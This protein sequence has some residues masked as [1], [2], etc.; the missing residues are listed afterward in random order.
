MVDPRKRPERATFPLDYLLLLGL[1]MLGGQCGSRRQLGRELTGSRLS[2]NVWKLAGKTCEAVCHTDTMNQV[3][4]GL[5][6]AGIERLIVLMAGRLRE[7]KMLRR[8]LLNG[9]LVVAMDGVQVMRV[10][11]PTGSGWLTQTNDGKTTY[12]HYVLAAKIITACGLV[13]PF[14]FEFIENPMELA[15]FDKQDCELKASRRLIEKIHRLYP[16]LKIALVGDGLF[17][18]EET[19]RR[20]EELGWDFLITLK[21]KKLPTV[22]VQLPAGGGMWSGTRTV[23][24]AIKGQ[25]EKGTH[26]VCW[27]TPVAY[28]RETYHVIDLTET[29]AGGVVTYHNTW[30]T[31]LKPN[32][33]NALSL[34]L[35]GRLRWKIENEGF[36]TQKNGGYEMEHGYGLGGNAWKNYYLLLQVAQ[37]LNNLV[38][39]TNLLATLAD[40]VRGTF[41]RLYGTMRN[42]AR[43]L[44]ESLRARLLDDAP[45]WNGRK[46]QV[47][48]ADD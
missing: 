28:H 46:V 2:A 43:R 3:M 19:F 17:A 30:I 9:N 25:A 1:L 11:H 16:R 42:Y 38:S 8:F 13:V 37:L 14:A 4:E 23:F 29:T 39:L 40:D 33:S 31:N 27:K 48:F 45:L 41:A 18:E 44:I 7:R 12:S 15:E 10:G 22:T 6:P 26:R 47:R 35:H 5:D 21:D 20:C 32:Q 24:A 34:A 36:N